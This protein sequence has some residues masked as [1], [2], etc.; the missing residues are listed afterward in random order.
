V[1]LIIKQQQAINWLGT[2]ELARQLGKSRSFIYFL[3]STRQIRY[4][5]IGGE[6]RFKPEWVEEYI[7]RNTF[8]PLSGEN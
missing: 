4:T 5:K 1:T 7:R 3:V 2:K 6:Y 8:E